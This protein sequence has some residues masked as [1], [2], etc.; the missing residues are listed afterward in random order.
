MAIT[1]PVRPVE[2]A[3]AANAAPVAPDPNVAVVAPPEAGSQSAVGNDDE[4]ERLGQQVTEVFQARADQAAQRTNGDGVAPDSTGAEGE[5]VVSPAVQPPAPVE[6]PPVAPAPIT[7]PG[8]DAPGTVP[9][10]TV[11]V[12]APAPAQE[13]SGVPGPVPG[14]DPFA[15]PPPAEPAALPPI[16]PAPAPSPAPSQTIQPGFVD[17]MGEIIPVQQAQAMRQT[18]EQVQAFQ[19]EEVNAINQFIEQRRLAL[20]NGQQ[21]PNQIAPAVQPVQP[22]YNP[23]VPPNQPAPYAQP[24]PV[25]LVT[26]PPTIDPSLVEDPALATFLNQQAQWFAQQQAQQ[27]QIIQQQ[28]QQLAQVAQSTEQVV[29]RDV[30]QQQRVN[31]QNMDQARWDFAVRHQL[32]PSELD[33]AEAR[34]VASGIVQP[35]VQRRNGDVYSAIL[36]GLETVLWTSPEL[37]ARAIAQE[38]APAVNDAREIQARAARVG[39][40]AGTGGAVV[41]ESQPASP[42][43][44]HEGMVSAIRTAMDQQPS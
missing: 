39:A 19:P 42:Q 1:P 23:A 36:D 8:T 3:Q 37:R 24:Q 30:E 9:I 2:D 35:L 44:R 4:W 11:P 5:A 43:Q 41:A 13:Q 10:P 26:P 29:L 25:G 34:L 32:S 21:P 20:A 31:F 16:Q 17:F 14:Y 27:Q 7:P 12:V 15:L 33:V 18:F 6:V 22:P 28:Q 38:T 40:L